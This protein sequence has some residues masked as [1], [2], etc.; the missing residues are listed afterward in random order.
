ML[1]KIMRFCDPLVLAVLV[2][3]YA[4]SGAIAQDAAWH[5]SKSSG[6][7]WVTASGMQP[8][9][10]TS[11]A[12]LKPGDTVH[13]GQNGRVLLVRG[14]ETILISANSIM[15][16]PGDRGSGL[17][18]TI[19]QQAGSILLDVEKRNVQHFEVLTPY[20]AAV[21][22]GTQFRVTVD[23]HGG[24][25]DVLRGQVQVTDYKSGQY[26]LVNPGQQASAARQGSA[27]LALSGSGSLSTIQPGTPRSPSVSPIT[28]PSDGFSA[29]ER[30]DNGLQNRAREGVSGPD[31]ADNGQPNR[32][33]TPERVAQAAPA[34]ADGTPGPDGQTQ[35]ASATWKGMPNLHMQ[36][37]WDSASQDGWRWWIGE[38]VD[39]VKGVLGLNGHTE[40]DEALAFTIAVPAFI[41]FSIAV[42]TGVVRQRRKKKQ[43]KQKQKPRRRLD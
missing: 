40:R 21:V 19:L 20:L 38:A 25:V 12:I 35:P 30:L 4:G 15:S 2:A 7:V 8:A 18:T 26:A 3:V 17:S 36:G 11:D 29:P 37:H 13:T 22:K 39:W 34:S 41:G 33:P 43:Q 6:E 28:I 31:R 42:G 9:A 24:R 16:I 10:L 27:G 14:P 32:M 1:S 5:V 23:N